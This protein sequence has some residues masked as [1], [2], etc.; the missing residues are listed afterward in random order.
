MD[1]DH[2]CRDV[3]TYLCRKNDG[4]LIRIV[5]PSFEIVCGWA[6]QGIPLTVACRGI[7][8]Y[9]GRHQ[10][11]HRRRPVRIDFCDADVLD[12]FDEWR[13]AVGVGV[14][15]AEPSDEDRGV[16]DRRKGSIRAHVDRVVLKISSLKATRL[17]VGLEGTLDRVLETLDGIRGSAKVFRGSTRARTI[18]ALSRLDTDMLAAARAACPE[19]VLAR[20]TIAARDEIAPFRARMPEEAYEKTTEASLER[21][22]RDHFELPRIAYE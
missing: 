20:L 17:P 16:N 13:R 18:E 3:E 19:D 22:V 8:R 14:A 4:H 21:Q 2:Y 15:G 7:D 12:V 9:F 10:R 6:I 1:F 5:G 11:D